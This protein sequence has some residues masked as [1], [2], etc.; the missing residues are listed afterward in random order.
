MK[1]KE[2]EARKEVNLVADRKT[3]R[4]IGIFDDEHSDKFY[5]GGNVVMGDKLYIG[6][7]KLAK[8]EYRIWRIGLNEEHTDSKIRVSKKV[9]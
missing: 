5:S 4:L 8:D 7:I 3:H 2:G 9:S 6:G 1:E